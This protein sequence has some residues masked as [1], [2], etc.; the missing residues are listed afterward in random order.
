MSIVT[1]RPNALPGIGLFGDYLVIGASG[2][3][4]APDQIN[5]DLDTTG[6]STTGP[7]YG[8][9]TGY[10]APTPPAG[11]TLRA[12]RLRARVIGNGSL[13]FIQINGTGPEGAPYFTDAYFNTAA[14]LTL[15]IAELPITS[16]PGS[17]IART[18]AY[19]GSTSIQILELYY[20]F[21]YVVPAFTI[22]TAPASGETIATNRPHLNLGAYYDTDGPFPDAYQVK[23]FTQAQVAAGGFN[24][25]TTTPQID[26]GS[27]VPH[28]PAAPSYTGGQAYR[29]ED[30][31]LPDGDYAAFG[32]FAQHV[33]GAELWGAWSQLPDGEEFTVDAPAP[34][35]PDMT[36]T[37]DPDQGRMRI[38]LQ[39]HIGDSPNALIEVQ[40]SINGGVSWEQLRTDQGG[41]A[42]GTVLAIGIGSDP[43][44]V[45]VY[46]YEGGNGQVVSYRARGIY[47]NFLIADSDSTYSGWTD[48][49]SSSWE[50]DTPQDWLKNPINPAQNLRVVLA[51]YPGKSS[52][53]RQSAMQ[54]LGATKPI[55]VADTRGGDTGSLQILSDSDETRTAIDN[56][57][58]ANVPLLLQVG[59]NEHEPDRYMVLGDQTR[60]RSVDKSWVGY[61]VDEFQWIEVDRPTGP[62]TWDSAQYKETLMLMSP[63][64]AWFWEESDPGLPANSLND[65]FTAADGTVLSSHTA[66]SGDTWTQHSAA[67]TTAV[68]TSN[69]IRPN[70]S[71]SAIYYSSDVPASADY[72]VEA[73]VRV[74]TN[75]GGQSIGIDA[76]LSTGADTTYQLLGLGFGGSRVD[77]YLTKRVAGTQ[78]ILAGPW[79][80]NGMSAGTDRTIQLK[81]EQ[82][83]IAG[84]IQG[85]SRLDVGAD[86]AITAAGRA[87]V[88]LNGGTSS[89]GFH[90][91]YVQS[92]PLKGGAANNGLVIDSAGVS[93]TQGGFLVGEYTLAAPS[94]PSIG[95]QSI[96]S[97]NQPDKG[98]WGYMPLYTPFATNAK[99]TFVG[100]MYLDPAGGGV[101]CMFAGQGLSSDSS[102]ALP[103]LEAVFD[104]GFPHR[105]HYNSNVS[106][107]GVFGSAIWYDVLPEG[108]WFHWALTVEDNV[109]TG[110]QTIHLFI[111]GK[112][113]DNVHQISTGIPGPNQDNSVKQ[114]QWSANSGPYV[115]GTRGEGGARSAGGHA[116]DGEHGPQAVFNRILTASEIQSLAQ[117]AGLY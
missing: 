41:D 103:V 86:S 100:S 19:S 110:Y 77:W 73:Q 8:L 76:R 4:S 26:S 94:L 78:T 55:V 20:D 48:K 104:G 14:P 33:N 80:D 45:T 113:M 1:V 116:I 12:A 7:S 46:D 70:T 36:L 83:S 17:I 115:V 68:I 24:P 66:D 15:T 29:D 11:G 54:P 47:V 39:G 43:P 31:V 2:S 117:S 3:G 40:R 51:S 28:G 75:V 27:Q 96:H 6:I 25:S 90:M 16:V 52:G 63:Q 9:E 60:T 61:M 67:A 22:V 106:V 13:R 92:R 5:D 84:I 34:D 99:R 53:A 95:V 97:H 18:D 87:G 58:R 32:R 112:T 107:M 108:E 64:A 74:V 62:L 98:G 23:V 50:D 79:Q 111:N 109:P 35:T 89:T 57:L 42:E 69:R 38:D 37:P 81:V 114:V 56:L 71:A 102:A 21:V 88:V 65:Q 91:N 59:P 72:V 85:V 44:P 30:T 10:P 82:N 101:P 93:T 49:Q 105:V